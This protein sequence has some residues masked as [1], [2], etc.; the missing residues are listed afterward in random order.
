M[1][2]IFFWAKRNGSV[3]TTLAAKALQSMHHRGPDYQ[4]LGVWDGS[5]FNLHS[6]IDKVAKNG[7]DSKE[8]IPFVIGHTRLSI[9]DL[10]PMGN[11]PMC[12]PDG[13]ILSFN[14]TIYN[15]IELREQLKNEG[16]SFQSNSDSEVLLQWLY[17]FGVNRNA[18]LNGSWA[19]TFVD[20]N[21]NKVTL[22]RDPYGERPLYYYN[23]DENYIVASEIKAIYIA[24]KNPTRSFEPSYV[25]AFLAY[26]YWSGVDPTQTF[27]SE[28]RR[29]APGTNLTIDLGSFNSEE[30]VTHSLDTHISH[31]P[32][33]EQIFND[34][35]RA[36]N[37]RLRADVPIGVLVSGGIDSSIIAALI[38]KD[39]ISRKNIIFYTAN[40]DETIS[41]D[42]PFAEQLAQDLGFS[43][44]KIDVPYAKQ[45]ID[46]YEKL[47]QKYDQPIPIDG[48]TM[49]ESLILQVMAADG[50]RVVISGTGGD[51]VFGG[52]S[53]TYIEGALSELLSKNKFIQTVQ[54]ALMA[55]KSYWTTTAALM[56][57]LVNRFKEKRRD[58][59][60]YRNLLPFINSDY[61]LVFKNVMEQYWAKSA[62]HISLNALQ[63]KDCINGRLSNYVS[64]GDTNSMTMSMEIRCPFL[65]P[66]LIK[67]VNMAVKDKYAEGFNKISL[68]KAMPASISKKITWRR[69]KQG[70]TYAFQKF[71]HANKQY[72]LKTIRD[73]N[74]LHKL[75][76]VDEILKNLTGHPLKFRLIRGLFALAIFS[77]S[78]SC[79]LENVDKNLLFPRPR[80]KKGVND[81]KIVSLNGYIL[82]RLF[83]WAIQGKKILLFEINPLFKINTKPL[84]WVASLLIKLNIVEEITH[85]FPNLKRWTDQG[86]PAYQLD[87]FQKAEPWMNRFYDFKKMDKLL[88]KF[89]LTYKH[90]TCNLIGQKLVRPILFD[91][92]LGLTVENPPEFAGFDLDAIELYRDIYKSSPK[93][94]VVPGKIIRRIVNSIYLIGGLAKM[95][96]F[97]LLRLRI[98]ST[99]RETVK[100]GADFIGDPRDK[101][102]YA[103]AGD[104]TQVILIPRN[105]SYWDINKEKFPG[106][107]VENLN[108]GF[109]TIGSGLSQISA[110]FKE[111]L[112]LFYHLNSR[113]PDLFLAMIRLEY[114]ATLYAA[115]FQKFGFKNFWGRDDYNGEHI[116][117]SQALR[118]QN[119]RSLG[120][121]H[122]FPVLA[123][124]IPHN[125]YID[126][127]VYFTFGIHA[128]EKY[129]KDTWPENMQICA[130]GTFAM[131][132]DRLKIKLSKDKPKDIIIFLKIGF[133]TIEEDAILEQMVEDIANAFQDRHVFV[134][135]KS[136]RGGN[137]EK[138]SIL[139][140]H[141]AAVT[142]NVTVVAHGEDPYDLFAKA[143]YVITD[144]SSIGAEAIQFGMNSLILDF[145]SWESLIFRDFPEICFL[146]TK[147]AIQRIMSIESGTYI[148]PREK[149]ESLI[150]SPEK[151]IEEIV[152][153]WMI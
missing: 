144:P 63:Q 73:S 69:Q 108:S 132:K 23:D 24:L 18:D 2:G 125:R 107:R 77:A 79:E 71:D 88:G 118:K 40:F 17:R 152:K 27:Y 150:S 140:T 151:S 20:V 36:V 106:Y 11:Q 25:A 4:A 15:Y 74:I 5:S 99:P 56:L 130:A 13:Q 65:D 85:A 30:T 14:G 82:P 78:N 50:I 80:N 34:L 93:Y 7:I 110:C 55:V 67:Y 127:D 137:A 148:Y 135:F 98:F 31:P 90:A 35:K 52:Y 58:N 42:R 112:F 129:Y 147:K 70:F 22:S 119:C 146:S 91:K 72:M 101:A 28:I 115:L 138:I 113:S 29:L 68:R 116:L 142:K 6:D 39:E 153:S 104:Q 96:A 38:D 46:N 83:W 49:S 114:K 120:L 54:F 122:G 89:A 53:D 121:N 37:I 84:N 94:S 26:N 76:D 131:N 3:D 81:I 60:P 57:F 62:H 100:L 92:I 19:F 102:I 51:E 64:W 143:T 136:W 95:V 48:S 149:F 123:S 139:E 10:S 124:L 44:R 47:V 128:Y 126:F 8:K 86:A 41:S 66:T 105:Q 109:F 12:T 21:D 117:R 103:L 141:W 133:W 45:A 16:I 87:I 59:S 33:P 43:L 134:K 145:P 9:I 1:C 61:R 75:F 97:I 111:S 32:N